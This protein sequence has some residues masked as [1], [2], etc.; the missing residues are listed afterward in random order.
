MILKHEGHKGH[1]VKKFFALLP[2]P[3]CVLSILGG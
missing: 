3:L 1:E 2:F